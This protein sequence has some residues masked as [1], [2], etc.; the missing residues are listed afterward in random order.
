MIFPAK[1]FRRCWPSSAIAG[2]TTALK[3]VEQIFEVGGKGHS[4]GIYSFDPDHIHRLA[5]MAPV[6]RIMVQAA[7]GQRQCGLVHQR[8]A[9]DGQPRVRY[10]GR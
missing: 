8:D 5:L 3:M 1:S 10:M 9:D 2:S 4:C 7:S 6:S